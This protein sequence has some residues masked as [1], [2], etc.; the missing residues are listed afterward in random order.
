MKRYWKSKIPH[1]VLERWSLCFSSCKNRKLKLKLWW[2]GTLKRIFILSKGKFLRVVF[3]LNVSCISVLTELIY[4]YI[5]YIYILYIYI[6]IIYIYISINGRRTNYKCII[7]TNRFMC[8]ITIFRLY[9]M[10]EKLSYVTLIWS[11]IKCKLM[12]KVERVG[13]A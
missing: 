6:Y 1:T 4:I 11:L 10:E 5:I 12:A 13:F 2:T 8:V 9:N 7:A 3:L